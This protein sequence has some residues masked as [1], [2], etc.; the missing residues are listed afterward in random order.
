MTGPASLRAAGNLTGTATSGCCNGGRLRRP[1]VGDGLHLPRRRV[2]G[3]GRPRR[4]GGGG[5]GHHR[6]PPRHA[7]SGAG[8]GLHPG[9][10][11]GGGPHR[12]VRGGMS[13]RY[14]WVAW[15]R[16][17]DRIRVSVEEGEI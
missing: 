3:V 15:R 14:P 1:R 11:S 17:E 16:R 7:C 4:D 5:G 8:G 10:G 2:C 6:C 13:G 12:R 9:R